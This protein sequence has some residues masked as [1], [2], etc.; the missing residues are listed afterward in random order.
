VIAWLALLPLLAADAAELD[1][2]ATEAYR[3]KEY[4]TAVALWEDALAEAQGPRE[5]ARLLYN[6]GNGAYR[7]GD[8]L[9]A[10]GWYTAALRLTP[11]DAAAWKNL[12]LA[13]SEAGLDPADRGDLAAT[14]Q[15]LLSALTRTEAEWLLLVALLGWAVCL[16]GEALRGGRPWRRA[17]WAGLLTVCVCAAPLAWHLM[18]PGG[19]PLMVVKEGGA[20]GRSEPRTDAASLTRLEAGAVVQRRDALPGWMC[21]EAGGKRVWI[22]E[23]AVFELA[24]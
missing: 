1:R 9:V 14:A 13:R 23:R 20:Q 8:P 16:G 12:E 5:R 24:R 2:R 4:A 21:V 17:G 22:R 10:V 15:R 7:R 6:L 3:A 11:R 18:Q 19:R